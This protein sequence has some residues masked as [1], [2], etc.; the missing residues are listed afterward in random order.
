MAD[1]HNSLKKYVNELT[2][3]IKRL[4]SVRG[5]LEVLL[6]NKQLLDNVGASASYSDLKNNLIAED[7]KAEIMKDPENGISDTVDA[8]EKMLN[9]DDMWTRRIIEHKKIANYEEN[10]KP[11]P[12]R[13][14]N[15]ESD[16]P[17]NLQTEKDLP[18]P[19]GEILP[20]EKKEEKR[21]PKINAFTRLKTEEQN[22]VLYSL[23]QEAQ[24]VVKSL[25]KEFS[26]EEEEK[27]VGEETDKLLKI[28]LKT[29]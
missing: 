3:V 24:K 5:E 22:K 23:Y 10:Q 8:L 20:E 25:K 11:P 13:K 12:P 9:D 28:W 21:D 4:D 14:T 18:T 26:P 27:L 2:S 6:S 29:H 15:N 16:R 19:E 17:D 1:I 7:P